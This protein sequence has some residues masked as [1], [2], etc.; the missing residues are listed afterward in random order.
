MQGA[1]PKVIRHAYHVYAG[2]TAW[3]D[4]VQV[5]LDALLA[6]E[7]A[8]NLDTL[9]AGLVGPPA[10]RAEA[11]DMLAAALPV[12]VLATADDGWEQVTLHQVHQ[13][14]QG[15]WAGDLVLYAHTKGAHDPS[16]INTA[17][18]ASMTYWNVVRW[19]EA[20]GHLSVADA[21]GCHWIV[22]G[23]RFFG[24]NYWWAAADYL[25]TLPPLSMSDRWCA[26]WW[27]GENPAVRPYDMV[28]GWPAHERFTTQ[29]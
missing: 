26:E 16:A 1:T 5:H 24:G 11:L 18:R 15:P 27:I 28:P 4:A 25:A 10:A 19:R 6:S 8:A 13:H 3:R 12:T 29:W 20:V 23:H 9:H 22:D 14:A 2:G 21:A 17:W 7:L